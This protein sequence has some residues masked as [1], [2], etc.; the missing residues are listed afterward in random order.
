MTCEQIMSNGKQ[1][2]A[3]AMHKNKFC[4]MHNPD[5]KNQVKEA[6][7]KGGQV[8]CYNK[9]LIKADPI[10]ILTDSKMVVYLLADTINRVR[11]VGPDGSLDPKAANCIGILTS[12]LLAAQKDLETERRLKRIEKAL[13][14]QGILK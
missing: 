7:R 13:D 2:K 5:T 9:G 12:K 4:F 8:S 1:C 3:N 14:A 6:G 10:D 11:Q